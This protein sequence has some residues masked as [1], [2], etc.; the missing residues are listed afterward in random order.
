MRA[1]IIFGSLVLVVKHI[2]GRA[3]EARMA[4]QNHIWQFWRRL[5]FAFLDSLIPLISFGLLEGWPP[6]LGKG[7]I[8]CKWRREA[9]LSAGPFKPAWTKRPS[10]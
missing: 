6:G 1:C 7:E 9:K 4:A 10:N 2:M 5:L 8:S 3:G